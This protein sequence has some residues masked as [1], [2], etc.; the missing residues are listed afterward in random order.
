MKKLILTLIL[1]PNIS[2]ASWPSFLVPTTEQLQSADLF[3]NVNC[4]IGYT[5]VRKGML[6]PVGRNTL[7]YCPNSWQWTVMND[8]ECFNLKNLKYITHTIDF[9]FRE[10]GLIQQSI[11][12]A[13]YGI[14][15]VPLFSLRFATPDINWRCYEMNNAIHLITCANDI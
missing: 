4:S 14:Q 2:V 12:T 3:E 1:F 10:Q 7:Q 9:T 8:T 13:H 15:G 6:L 5:K 11:I